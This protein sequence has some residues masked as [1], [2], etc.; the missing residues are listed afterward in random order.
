MYT[1]YNKFLSNKHQSSRIHG[2]KINIKKDIYKYKIF[3][4]KH[5]YTYTDTHTHFV[6]LNKF[7][8]THLAIL[9]QIN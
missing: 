2:I 6:I 8:I 3:I 7:F 4:Y 5:I 9:N 1:N